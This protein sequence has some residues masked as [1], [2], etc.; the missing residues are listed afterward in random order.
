MPKAAVAIKQP[1]PELTTGAVS[2]I[3]K[4]NAEVV[5]PPGVGL[6]TVTL[7]EP[8]VAI[9]PAGIVTVNCVADTRVVGFGMSALFH[10]IF[11]LLTKLVPL[12]VSR[13]ALPPGLVQ[14]GLK[15]LIVGAGLL[16][17]VVVSAWPIVGD[18]ELVMVAVLLKSPL[19]IGVTTITMLA[20]LPLLIVPR[21]QAMLLVPLH[22]P[23]LG[24]A[25]T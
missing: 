21:L 17:V 10:C 25:E 23:W 16:T 4:V 2:L 8:A 14:E 11:E 15:E 6:T 24:V 5:P 1:P 22:E 19:T 9:S 18:G 12:T 20:L 13:N 3:A 7:A